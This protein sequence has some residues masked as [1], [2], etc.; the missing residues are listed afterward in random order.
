MTAVLTFAVKRHP[1]ALLRIRVSSCPTLSSQS[2]DT[3][4]HPPY[5][6]TNNKPVADPKGTSCTF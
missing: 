4:P 5:V 3:L 6:G 1:D 2:K